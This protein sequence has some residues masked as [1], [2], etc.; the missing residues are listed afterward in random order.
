MALKTPVGTVA[1]P[2]LANPKPAKNS[3]NPDNLLYSLVLLFTEAD[4]QTPEFKALQKAVI[5][6]CFEALGKEKASLLIKDKKIKLGIRE[7]VESS[8]FP[9][10]YKCFIR[11]KTKNKPGMVDRFADP[12]TG[13]PIPLADPSDLYSGSKA[14]CLVSLKYWDIDGGKSVTWY[15]NHIQKTGDGERIDGRVAAEDAFEA[16]ESA[17]EVDIAS[18]PAS[19]S[20]AASITS[21]E[22]ALMGLLG[23]VN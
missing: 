7:D 3:T 12:K 6:T 1:F 18:L 23:G 11:M 13:K 16:L 22:E 21:D 15:V 9:T 19:K 10:E 4:M 8:G 14:R 20:T 17:Q 5:E 2:V